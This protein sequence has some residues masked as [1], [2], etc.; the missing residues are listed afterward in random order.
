MKMNV[1]SMNDDGSADCQ[2]D[3]THEELIYFA[4]IGI[5]KV[6]E[7]TVKDKRISEDESTDRKL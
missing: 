4:K 6:L 5:L 2:I 7:D 3:M 1:M